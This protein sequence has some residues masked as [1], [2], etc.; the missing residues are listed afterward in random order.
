MLA[1]TLCTPDDSGGGTAGIETGVWTVTLVGITELTVDFRLLLCSS[2]TTKSVSKP[3]NH[4]GDKARGNAESN[5]LKKET[6]ANLPFSDNSLPIEKRLSPAGRR[7]L[8]RRPE[9]DILAGQIV[10][11]RLALWLVK[12]KEKQL[13]ARY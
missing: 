3:R 6:E 5:E 7:I 2:R 9:N 13:T 10:S 12:S 11:C 1:G 4:G 8:T